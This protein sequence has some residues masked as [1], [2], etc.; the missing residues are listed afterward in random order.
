MQK[1][2]VTF[3]SP[4]TFVFEETT[5]EI[6]S[7]DPDTAVA[8]AREV[9][10][11]Y[12]ATP[13][14]FYFT[15]RTRGETDLDSKE[16]FRSGMFYLGGT[17]ETIEQVRTRNDPSERILLQNMEANGF[18]RIIVNRNS[19]RATQPFNEGDVVLPYEAKGKGGK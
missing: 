4:G 17:I 9:V 1:H 19:W 13:F 6:P 8:M 5:Q 18:A 16:S 11:R 7:W 12:N 10:E 2:F 15:T 3:L 14:G